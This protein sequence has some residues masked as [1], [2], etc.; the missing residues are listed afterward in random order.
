MHFKHTA[1]ELTHPS[2]PHT[3]THGGTDVLLTC[4]SFMDLALIVRKSSRIQQSTQAVVVV[5]SDL[6]TVCTCKMC[7]QCVICVLSW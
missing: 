1:Y 6:E 4:E 2:S 7:D 3:H 5:C